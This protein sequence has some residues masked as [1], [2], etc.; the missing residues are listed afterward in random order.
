MSRM[1][2]LLGTVSVL[3]TLAAG[4]AAADTLMGFAG[5]ADVSYTHVS[6]SGDNGFDGD[7]SNSFGAG[8][9]IA[10]PI[11]EIAGF[12]WELNGSYFSTSFDP[13]SSIDWNLGGSIFWA[14]P[15][16]RF[17]VN[18]NY[19]TITDYGSLTNGGVFTE[20]YFGNFTAQAKGGWL[21]GGG[22]PAGGRG[23]YLG[24]GLVGYFVPNFAV[25]ADVTWADLV[26]SATQGTFCYGPT[27]G[28]RD[29]THTDF[30]IEGE[31]LVSETFP[32]SIYAGYQYTKLSLSENASN[33]FL[34]DD[35]FNTNTFYVGLRFYMG[36]QGTLIEHHRNGNLHKFLRGANGL[37]PL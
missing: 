31:F 4:P 14:G 8:A 9:A 15:G 26:T 11:D 32:V 13:G 23:N 7:G 24:A 17:G 27:C 30:G 19:N 34:F 22:T 37:A 10:F 20:W 6:L 36:G 18:V 33:P 29:L 1:T 2:R 35:D 28:R 25:S 21:W 12:N 3:A 5:M 16:S